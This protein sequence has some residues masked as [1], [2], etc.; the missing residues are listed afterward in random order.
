MASLRAAL[1]AL[2]LSVVLA[3][4]GLFVLTRPSERILM[5]WTAPS[6]EAVLL[7]EGERN[8]GTFP[9]GGDRRHYV[10]V[11]R[12]PTPSGYGH[13]VSFDLHSELVDPPLPLET[14]AKH[15]RAAFSDTGLEIE[16]PSGHRLFIPRRAYAGGR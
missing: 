10:Y 7:Y 5:R 15:V 2:P 1:P 11:G 9:F 13:R 12:E 14:Y 4:G 3:L 8:Y 6:G 16:E